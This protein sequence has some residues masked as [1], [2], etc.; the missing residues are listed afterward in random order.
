[1]KSLNMTILLSLLII[2]NVKSVT[3]NY[4]LERTIFGQLTR[5]YAQVYQTENGAVAPFNVVSEYVRLDREASHLH[6]NIIKDMQFS[7]TGTGSKNTN[8]KVEVENLVGRIPYELV[9]QFEKAHYRNTI[10]PL[11][12]PENGQVSITTSYLGTATNKRIYQ[13]QLQHYYFTMV[14]PDRNG[15]QYTIF[16]KINNIT[17]HNMVNTLTRTDD[18]TPTSDDDDTDG[19]NSTDDDD[20]TDETDGTQHT[21]TDDDDT[22]GTQHTDTDDDDTDGY[23]STEDDD[24]DTG[25]PSDSSEK[26]MNSLS[27]GDGN[28]IVGVNQYPQGMHQYGQQLQGIREEPIGTHQDFVEQQQPLHV[29]GNNPSESTQSSDSSTYISSSE[30]DGSPILLDMQGHRVNKSGQRIDE[31]GNVIVDRAKKAKLVNRMLKGFGKELTNLLDKFSSIKSDTSKIKMDHAK[32]Q[33]NKS[34]KIPSKKKNSKIIKQEKQNVKIQKEK[35]NPL[36]HQIKMIKKKIQIK[37]I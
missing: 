11:T 30:D 3:R 27:S 7:M 19:N 2:A 23:T 5:G 28:G 22:D 36:I 8:S 26:S 15:N 16:F 35:I 31:N 14:A 1:M 6:K 17:V 29:L 10:G 21:D 37:I 12:F 20:G 32:N 33:I 18:S 4:D 25:S 9:F 34:N 24:D 13:L